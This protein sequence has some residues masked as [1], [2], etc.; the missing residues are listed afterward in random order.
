MI[1][2]DF[3][4]LNP[5][6]STTRLVT[7]EQPIVE[8]DPTS[9]VQKQLFLPSHKRQG[10][11]G[12]RINGYF[13][14]NLE[15]KPLVSII[16]VVYNGCAYIAQTIESVLSQSYDN[17]EYII[18]D[19]GSTDGTVDIIQKYEHAI[20]YW[21]SEPDNGIYD[22]MNKGIQVACGE[23]IWM[24]N[25]DDYLT[26]DAIQ[27][28]FLEKTNNFPDSVAIY[29]CLIKSFNGFNLVIGKRSLSYDKKLINF[30]HPATIMHCSLFKKY[31]AFDVAYRLSSDYDFFMRLVRNGIKFDFVDEVLATMRLDGSSDRVAN[32]FRRGKEH[33]AI[34]KKYF[35]YFVVVKNLILFFTRDFIKFI[36]RKALI[37]Q[38]YLYPLRLYFS[39][40]N[41]YIVR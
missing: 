5:N 1:A 30:N 16:T 17:V 19:G 27:K 13:K 34:D 24:L 7:K 22:A 3:F 11:G 21:V 40:K 25:A 6:Y 14:R 8:N 15:T 29:G 36:I 23:W 37:K 28:V 39:R 41:E 20:D 38:R 31:G 4:C 26:N 18:I 12:L 33:F 10:N 9:K 32:Y 35:S 2:R